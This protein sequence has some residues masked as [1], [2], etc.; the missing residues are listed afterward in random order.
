MSS[1]KYSLALTIALPLA[2]CG[3]PELD[4]PESVLEEKDPIVGGSNTTI[5]MHPWQISLQSNSG[6]AFCGGSIVGPQWILTANHCVE[7][8][9]PSSMRV[10]AG[11]TRI[12]ESNSGQIRSVDQ[13]LMFPGYVSAEQGRDAA[14]L[15]LSQPL[16]LSGARARAIGI[17]TAA[18]AADGRTNPGVD[19]VVTGWGTLRSGGSTPDILQAVTVPIVSNEDAEEAYG[20]N[21]T[22][23]QLAAGLLGVGGRDSCQGDSG[24]P[25]T[26]PSANGGR[27]LAGIVSWG[28]GC[29]DP[30]FPGMYGRVS[31]FADWI[32]ANITTNAAPAVSI[33]APSAGQTI[34][35]I[36]TAS[37][38]AADSD[39]TVARVRFIFPD[40]T[41]TDVT[42]APYTAQWDS[43]TVGDGSVTIRAEAYDNA[44]ARGTASVQVNASNGNAPTCTNGSFPATG[45]PISIPDNNTTGISSSLPISGAG[46]V[47]TLS[48]SLNIRHTYR[49][50]LVVTLRSPNGT[51]FTVHN[52]AGGSADNLVISN[53]AIDAFRGQTIAGTWS[54]RVQD[55]AR[56]DVGTLDS[57]SLAITG[58]CGGGGGGWTGSATP[59]MATVDNG[60]A[61]SSLTV[62]GSGSASG[63]RLDLSGRHDYRSILRA[64]LEHN[65]VTATAFPTGTFSRGSGTFSFTG[66][67]ISGFTGDAGGTWTLCIFDTDA[68]GDT[69]VLNSW[70]VHN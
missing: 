63:V 1:K 44:G 70:S 21:I 26:V 13:I 23:D 11:I 29:A 57:W 27:L 7:G 42:S 49:G 10:V 31:A 41:Q 50:D 62:S 4:S 48:L 2:A 28:N 43:R 64:T 52:Q 19:S 59:N 5:E 24:G 3:G 67:A 68:F 30:N 51:S 61:C 36:I 18:D 16:D 55:V 22:D 9:A 6:F 8:E 69:G 60:R 25:L 38:N 32:L 66:R 15:H 33:T 20:Q 47:A 58:D 65:G 46:T 56:L 39:G 12:S 35:G 45:L 54:L 14:L 53:Q 37:A 34:T 17:V 40:G